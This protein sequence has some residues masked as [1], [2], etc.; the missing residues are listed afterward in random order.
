MW[1]MITPIRNPSSRPW[2]TG[3]RFLIDSDL[4]K[5]PDLSV[6]TFSTGTIPNIIIQASVSWLPRTSIMDVLSRLSKSDRQFFT[7][8]I[9]TSGTVQRQNAQRW[10]LAHCR[11]D[12]QTGTWKKRSGDTLNCCRKCLKVIDK[13][14]NR[15]WGFCICLYCSYA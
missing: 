5:M 13:F 9:K 1:V 11:L 6:R 4:L 12:Q 15:C 7:L 14:R 3:R 10:G 8:P 2:N